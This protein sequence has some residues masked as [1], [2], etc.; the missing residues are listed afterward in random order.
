MIVTTHNV[1]KWEVHIYALYGLQVTYCSPIG[2]EEYKMLQRLRM[3]RL[4]AYD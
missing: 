4:G 3:I 1:E 2:W